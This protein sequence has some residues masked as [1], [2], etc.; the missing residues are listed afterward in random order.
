MS[1]YSDLHLIF[2]QIEGAWQDFAVV[3]KLIKSFKGLYGFGGRFLKIRD[4]CMDFEPYFKVHNLVSVHPKS[5][6]LGQMTNLNTIFHEVMSVY[7]L[8]KIWNSP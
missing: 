6:I 3:T 1:K 4:V 5:I 8:V 2:F 7:R